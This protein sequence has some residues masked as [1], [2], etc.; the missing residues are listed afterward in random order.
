[1]ESLR[2]KI[3]PNIFEDYMPKKDQGHW[4]AELYCTE[5][6]DFLDDQDYISAPVEQSTDCSDVDVVDND[7]EN[8]MSSDLKTINENNINK[9]KEDNKN[10]NKVDKQDRQRKTSVTINGK[11]I[12]FTEHNCC[13]E[14]LTGSGKTLVKYVDIDIGENKTYVNKDGALTNTTKEQQNNSNH[15]EQEDFS[16]ILDQFD[17]FQSELNEISEGLTQP[18]ERRFSKLSQEIASSNHVDKPQVKDYQKSLSDKNVNTLVRYCKDEHYSNDKKVDEIFFQN[19][20]SYV[21]PQ[22]AN[23]DT[24]K[25]QSLKQQQSDETFQHFENKSFATRRRSL[26]TGYLSQ[27]GELIKENPLSKSVNDISGRKTF[28][29]KDIYV[30]SDY[31]TSD[32]ET[33]PL[34]TIFTRQKKKSFIGKSISVDVETQDNG[35][36]KRKYRRRGVFFDSKSVESNS[37]EDDFLSDLLAFKKKYKL[38]KREKSTGLRIARSVENLLKID[39]TSFDT[40]RK[41]SNT[42]TKETK[43]TTKKKTNFLGKKFRQNKENKMEYIRETSL[44]DDDEDGAGDIETETGKARPNITLVGNSVQKVAGI[45]EM[46]M[47]KKGDVIRKI[48]IHKVQGQSLGFFIR[49]GNGIERENGIFISRVT[50]GSFVDVNNLLHAGDEIL[51]INKV[52]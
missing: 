19:T 15:E 44:L 22:F 48:E 14:V 50:L 46:Y 7:E 6:S 52:S 25:H 42:E 16:K 18:T 3:Q 27:P 32:D 11:F 17:L 2:Y 24:V 20:F 41:R 45:I 33:Q 9:N 1:M 34:K 21:S 38:E 26:S 4:S 43:Q 8:N 23:V 40:T 30:E 37:E 49:F 12:N 28:Y 5:K 13:K 35:F 47:D 36:T 31:T 10:T 39:K 29:E 51:T